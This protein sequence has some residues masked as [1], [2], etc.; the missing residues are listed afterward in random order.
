LELPAYGFI[1][2]YYEMK[3]AISIL[4]ARLV[5]E[6]NAKTAELLKQVIAH[7]KVVHKNGMSPAR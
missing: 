3:E 1:H 5:E 7:L 4:E 6:S 2:D